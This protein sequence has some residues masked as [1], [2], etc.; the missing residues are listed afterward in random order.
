[1]NSPEKA[2]PLFRALSAANLVSLPPRDYT[3]KN[4]LPATGLAVIYGPPG[5][6]KTFM[7]LDG[8]AR[9]ARGMEWCGRRTKPRG[10]VLVALEGLDGIAGRAAAYQIHHQTTLPDCMQVIPAD[11]FS[12]ADDEGVR[13]LAATVHH[14]ELGAHPVIVIDTLSAATFGMD[15]NSAS[16]MGAVMRRLRLLRKLT[17]GLVVLIAHTG[18]ADGGAPRGS[19]VLPGE[20]DVMIGVRKSKSDPEHRTVTVEKQRD[21]SSVGEWWEFRL[22]DIPYGADTDGDVLSSCVVEQVADATATQ[23]AAKQAARSPKKSLGPNE[24]IVLDTVKELLNQ[25]DLLE[26][27]KDAL[28]EAE[29]RDAVRPKLTCQ[30]RKVAERC[31]EAIESLVSKGYLTRDDVF[32]RLAQSRV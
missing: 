17:A 25:P 32:I 4:L 20:C 19:S 6:G 9:I 5:A 30:P 12:L 28:H 22:I 24:K 18:K 16:E 2:P 8:L 3:V 13:R 15:E 11:D 7:V 1:M 31:R 14:L 27:K 21:F 26:A 23:P 29:I 10:V